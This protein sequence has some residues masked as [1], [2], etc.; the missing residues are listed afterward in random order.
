MRHT[1]KRKGSHRRRSRRSRVGAVDVKKIGMKIV[2]VTAG[3]F[4]ARTLNNVVVKQFPTALSGW[5]LGAGDAVIGALVPKFLKSDLGV[6]IGDGMIAIGA[7]TALQSLGV[8][9]GIGAA[10]RRVPTRVIGAGAQPF[11]SKMVGASARPY[12]RQT[13]GSRVGSAYSE[14]ETMNRQALGRAIGAL[15]IEE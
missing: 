2:G 12:M 4:A 7:L 14:M 13:V 6:A 1:K 11:L 8:L 9:Q 10:P 5:M 3:A 15:A